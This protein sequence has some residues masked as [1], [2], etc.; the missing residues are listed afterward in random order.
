MNMDKQLTRRDFVATAVIGA[1]AS[2]SLLAHAQAPQVITKHSARPA[3]VASANGNK[4]KDGEGLTCVAKAFKMIT[5]GSDVLDAV[6]AGV[7][8]L[9]LDPE[10]T[11]VGYGGAAKSAGVGEIDASAV[12]GPLQPGAALPCLPGGQMPVLGSPAGA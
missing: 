3:V 8:I 2:P 10:D 1:L 11:S 7:T 4:S 6:I 5:E 12:D 9:E